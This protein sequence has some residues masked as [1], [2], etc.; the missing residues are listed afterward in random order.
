[1]GRGRYRGAKSML[2]SQFPSPFLPCHNEAKKKCMNII[3]VVF[4]VIFFCFVS[5]SVL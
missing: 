2:M 4:A 1:V 5:E 3:L